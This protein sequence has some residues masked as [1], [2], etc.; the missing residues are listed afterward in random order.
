MRNAFVLPVILAVLGF[1]SQAS[2]QRA[3]KTQRNDV[4]ILL[5]AANGVAAQAPQIPPTEDMRAV[6]MQMYQAWQWRRAMHELAMAR[7]RVAQAAAY[8]AQ[9]GIPQYPVPGYG[10]PGGV[11]NIGS[12]ALPTRGAFCY[13]G[14]NSMPVNGAYCYQK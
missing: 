10:I 9:A 5:G 6:R 3:K 8:Q 7:L 1:A 14:A 13:G 2:A 12:N 4:D 11:I